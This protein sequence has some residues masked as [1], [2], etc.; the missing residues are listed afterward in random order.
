[1]SPTADEFLKETCGGKQREGTILQFLQSARLTRAS[2]VPLLAELYKAQ[3]SALIR[4]EILKLASGRDQFRSG[5]F[6]GPQDTQ[7]R[8]NAQ[9]ML[10]MA[11][12]EVSKSP[13]ERRPL[14]SMLLPRMT[15][16]PIYDQRL[17]EII[18]AE[19]SAESRAELYTSLLKHPVNKYLAWLLQSEKDPTVQVSVLRSMRESMKGQNRFMGGGFGGGGFYVDPELLRTLRDGQET[20]QD[21]AVKAELDQIV[22]GMRQKAIASV[23]S[24]FEVRMRYQLELAQR[25]DTPENR[26]ARAVREPLD[27][28]PMVQMLTDQFGDLPEEK[29]FRDRVE[30]LKRTYDRKLSDVQSAQK[31]SA[32]LE[33]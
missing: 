9:T 13:D 20:I 25:P 4:D 14:L 21:A 1:M 12:L 18:T 32:G 30:E 29:D 19:P 10:L 11:L 27:A 8:E 7:G 33:N 15:Q 23:M 5:D 3:G 26:A 28:E 16:N 22:S 31:P 2:E 17:R 6:A 24:Q